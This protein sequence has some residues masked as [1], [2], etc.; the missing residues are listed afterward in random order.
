M[1]QLATTLPANEARANFYDLIEE[2]ATKF[3]TF[4]ITHRG[5][6]KAVVMS[7]DELESWRETLEIMSENPNI[8]KDLA[9]SKKEVKEGKTISLD[10]LIKKYDL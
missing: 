5:T 10:N 4:T 6:P 3:K 2:V 7:I 8:L 1:S 9:K